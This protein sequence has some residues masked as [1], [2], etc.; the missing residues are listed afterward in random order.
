MKNFRIILLA[1][2]IAG[3][4]T[5]PASAQLQLSKEQVQSM[6]QKAMENKQ[7]TE[8]G[9]SG[10]RRRTTEDSGGGG[11]GGGKAGSWAD[12]RKKWKDREPVNQGRKKRGSAWGNLRA[13]LKEGATQQGG[14]VESAIQ[15]IIKRQITVIAGTRVT[16]AITGELLD[17]AREIR[18]DEDKK[19]EYYDDGTHGDLV[20]GDGQ[21]TRVEEI[22][23][24]IGPDNQRIK[25][26]LIQALYEVSRLD[27][28]EFYGYTLMSTDHSTR[29][30]RNVRW[31]LVDAPE[32]RPGFRLSEIATDKSVEVPDFWEEEMSRD[33]KI[34]G[35]NGWAR[36]FLDEYR[37]EK[38][39]LTSNFYLPYVPQPPTIP[40]LPPPEAEGWTPFVASYDPESGETVGAAGGQQDPRIT[41]ATGKAQKAVAK[42]LNRGSGKGSTSGGYFSAE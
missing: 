27:A 13:Q 20:A 16:D 38:G 8:E 33:M 41:G 4:G 35:P 15:K 30:E 37:V 40:K 11:G 39:G 14:A 31:A 10:S 42:W 1:F 17:D 9:G 22:T 29:P 21:Y 19:D 6:M 36:S 12:F 18:V 28:R 24:V 2:A 25:E 23:G 5:L 3:C 32:D 34:A 26:R 7:K